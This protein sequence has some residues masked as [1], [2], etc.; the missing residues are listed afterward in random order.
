MIK[1]TEKC[2]CACGGTQRK[3]WN[4]ADAVM[5]VSIMAISS[6]GK[7]GKK[8]VAALDNMAVASPLYAKISDAREYMG[9]I[10][11]V[12]YDKGRFESLLEAK[13]VLS[14]QMRETAYAWA[15]QMVMAD[16]KIVKPE[17]IFLSELRR[18]MGIH[19]AFA[20]KINAVVSILNRVK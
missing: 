20:G 5:A 3:L 2:G 6:D 14:P 17:H 11:S 10:A 13:K 8:E 12:I 15:V 1:K 16:E 7:L 18:I 4:A 9:C 19:G